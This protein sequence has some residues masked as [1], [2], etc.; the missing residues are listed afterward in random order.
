MLEEE[1]V[2]DLF[3]HD[4]LSHLNEVSHEKYRTYLERKLKEKS[5]DRNNIFINNRN[6]MAILEYN[7]PASELLSNKT[8]YIFKASCPDSK[9]CLELLK[10]IK[11]SL[12]PG[13]L[14]IFR[15]STEN[16]P[17]ISALTHTG[18][19]LTETQIIYLLK[20]D[21]MNLEY[22]MNMR[23]KYLDRAFHPG[24]ND[25]ETIKQLIRISFKNYPNR[26]SVDPF[27]KRNITVELYEKWAESVIKKS[28]DGGAFA[29]VVREEKGKPCA[30]AFEE[31]KEDRDFE[32]IFN[33]RTGEFLLYFSHPECRGKN[34]YTMITSY[35]LKIFYDLGIDYVITE[36]HI[37]NRYPQY[38]WVKQGFR[39]VY[40]RYTFNLHL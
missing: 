21:K 20:R 31:I 40:S 17:L 27:L 30:G 12:D 36:T 3:M 29:L 37:D 25:L 26:F 18:A 15:I 23:E 35:G 24:L 32:E 22:V 33:L 16:Y 8:Y 13:S 4:L 38:V 11:E 39:P 2:K 6:Y 28:M 1:L 7:S 10:I 34:Y 19:I 14:V 5:Y 9:K